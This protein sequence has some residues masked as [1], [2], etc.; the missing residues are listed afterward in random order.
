MPWPHR[1]AP[2][3]MRYVA[4]ARLFSA[5]NPKE[6]RMDPIKKE[7]LE[8]KLKALIEMSKFTATDERNVSPQNRPVQVI[9]RRK[10]APDK[11]IA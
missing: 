11:R 5:I 1:G 2:A 3:K 9:R 4:A 10:G 7:K 6:R 8:A